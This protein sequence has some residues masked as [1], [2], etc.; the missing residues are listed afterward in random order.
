[1]KKIAILIIVLLFN[2]KINAQ[3]TITTD[4]VT[5]LSTCAGSSIVVSYKT[6]GTF[7]PLGNTFTAQI[8]NGFGS[9]ANPIDIGSIPFNLGFIPATLPKT[10]GFGFLY[11]IRVISTNPADTGTACP[12]TL[13]ITQV[14]QF[15]QIVTSCQGD[16]TV[17]TALNP[18][19]SYS[20][21]TG[22]TTSSITPTGPGI[23]SVTTKDLL[24]CKSTV[25]DTI[26]GPVI[27]T[28]INE[29]SI[30][31]I[32]SVYPNPS[33]GTCTISITKTNSKDILLSVYDILGKEVF[34][35]SDKSSS[36]EYKKDIHL[37][38]LATGIYSLKLTIGSDLKT[39][40]II[41]Q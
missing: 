15:N 36:T 26:T 2:L 37:E 19:S 21:S 7:P 25:S 8:S 30:K 4:S 22:D 34:R 18:G 9:F 27:C 33:N 14:A 16:S 6:T 20:W 32:F 5:Q 38:H 39:Q 13:I 23:Y 1:M 11:K 24:G 28:G 29:L 40:K 12:N 35:L 17:L 31:N 3:T 41:I 10:L